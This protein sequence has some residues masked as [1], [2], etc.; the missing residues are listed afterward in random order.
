VDPPDT[1]WAEDLVNRDFNP[2]GPDRLW[3]A[4]MERHEALLHE[5]R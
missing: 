4:D 1:A 2:G 3:A 5:R